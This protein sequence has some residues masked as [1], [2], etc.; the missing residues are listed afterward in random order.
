[1]SF[2]K[3]LVPVDGSKSSLQSLD[4]AAALAKKMGSETTII[5]V[6]PEFVGV[7]AEGEPKAIGNEVVSHFDQKAESIMADARSLLAEEGIDVKADVLR[8]RDPADAILEFAKDGEYD[9]IIMGN[10]EDDRWELDTVGGVAERAAKRWS[11]PVLIVK[12]TC[13]FA[14]ISVVVGS[15]REEA[16]FGTAANL[17][18]DFGSQFKVIS[19]PGDGK[20]SGDALLDTYL[21]K[22]K[23]LGLVP[24]GAAMPKRNLKQL[25]SMLTTDL[26]QLLL[27]ERPA[28][29]MFSRIF[30]GGD[31][32]YRI[33][34]SCPCSVMVCP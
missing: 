17:A 10:G 23:G 8:Y 18:K 27:V 24:Q 2:K 25:N 32:A 29:G 22:A 11:G 21:Q 33:V 31:W 4:M 9:L 15:G 34:A 28:S 7:P 5:H 13:G 14:R 20:A 6:I 16:L 30:G 1:M 12:K 3:I 26:T 19:A